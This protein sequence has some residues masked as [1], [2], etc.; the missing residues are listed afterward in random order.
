MTKERK[1]AIQIWTEIK[2]HILHSE[3]PVSGDG[4][5]YRKTALNTRYNVYWNYGCWFC[6]YIRTPDVPYDGYSGCERCPLFKYAKQQ[7]GACGC[8]V[9]NRR[10]PYALLMSNA[11]DNK[12]KV[13]ACDIIIAALKGKLE[14]G[15]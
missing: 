10:A 6:H 13:E 4:V 14:I 12:T 1:L 8:D 11:T 3:H 7:R 5:L 9:G 2:E 15:D